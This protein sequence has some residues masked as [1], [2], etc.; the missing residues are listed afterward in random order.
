MTKEWVHS[1]PRLI[2]DNE[3]SVQEECE[4]LFLELV[5]DRISRVG[6]S[7]SVNYESV[8]RDAK[9]KN[10]SSDMEAESYPEEV[11]G[12]L[13]EIC[14]AEVSLWVKKICSSLGKKRKLQKNIV[15]A[16]QNI[17]KTSESRWLNNFM[18]IEKWT[19]PSGAWFLL[20]EVSSFLSKAVDW[21]FLHHHWQLFDKFKP[22]SDLQ[23]PLRRGSVEEDMMDVESSSVAWARDR[24]FL[25]QSIA[26]VAMEL[27]PEPAAE[28]AQDFLK[29]LEGFNMHTTEVYI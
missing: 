24:V 11:L 10:I 29:R 27:P 4:N 9:G 2:S 3:T 15:T 19:A 16:L 1:V 14:D 23:S 25:L 8:A 5:L 18:P 13:E 22:V 26:N 21:E 6:L 12:L 7:C 28:L 17:I 20:S